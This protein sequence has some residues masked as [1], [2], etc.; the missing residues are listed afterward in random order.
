MISAGVMVSWKY[1]Y[2]GICGVIWN[3]F[4]MNHCDCDF[5]ICE[6]VTVI[7]TCYVCACPGGGVWKLIWHEALC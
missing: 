2:G 1:S 7:L 6:S 5:D 4:C 3:D